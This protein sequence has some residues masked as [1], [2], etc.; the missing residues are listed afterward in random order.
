[1]RHVPSERRPAECR[2]LVPNAHAG[3]ASRFGEAACT[4]SG[5]GTQIGT[6]ADLH[7]L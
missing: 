4:P 7:E 5:D 6:N 3:T 2:A 1:M